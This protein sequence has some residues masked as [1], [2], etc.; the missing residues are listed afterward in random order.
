MS[1]FLDE[2]NRDDECIHQ[3][4]GQKFT[5]ATRNILLEEAKALSSTGRDF[6][7]RIPFC[8]YNNEFTLQA[9]HLR[10]RSQYGSG[11][12]CNGIMLCPTCHA[13]ADRGLWMEDQLK[14]FKLK[15]KTK[16]SIDSRITK[17]VTIRDIIAR[18]YD[19]HPPLQSYRR[20]FEFYAELLKQLNYCKPVGVNVDALHLA[21]ARLLLHIAN[22]FN[23]WDRADWNPS[24]IPSRFSTR[25]RSTILAR[26]ARLIA[27]R[28]EEEI[29]EIRARH[30]LAVN[31]NAMDNL[32]DSITEAKEINK[33]IEALNDPDEKSY[34]LVNLALIFAKAGE[35][36]KASEKT[37]RAIDL[38]DKVPE[39]RLAEILIRSCQVNLLALRDDAEDDLKKAREHKGVLSP[40]QEI[41]HERTEALYSAIMRDGKH[42][43][44]LPLMRAR[45]LALENDMNH[46]LGKIERSLEYFDSESFRQYQP[47]IPRTAQHRLAS[48]KLAPQLIALF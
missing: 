28:K 16:T 24:E 41:I 46:Q 3:G 22:L 39:S 44:H 7:C 2:P 12:Q 9:H 32:N 19:Q 27:V 31:Y 40:M 33:N 4:K 45:R 17:S 20:R 34:L 15:L 8:D 5:D 36:E 42:D 25:Y 29:L 14:E 18:I 1:L 47:T 13:E 35:V 38:A 43:I 30:T 23:S 37:K 6:E 10:P 11:N 48:C 26:T 21:R